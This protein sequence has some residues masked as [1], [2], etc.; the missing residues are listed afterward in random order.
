MNTIIIYDQCGEADITF[1]IVE[2]DKS[3][4][5]KI[6]IN[7]CDQDEA[8]QDELYELIQKYTAI[9]DFPIYQIGRETRVIV[10][11]FLA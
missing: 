5:N 8:L 4:L 9:K 2:G 11:G 6:Y 7:A 3:H 10:A 1:Y